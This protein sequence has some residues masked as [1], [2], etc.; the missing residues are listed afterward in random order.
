MKK[1]MMGLLV[2]LM[3]VHAYADKEYVCIDLKTGKD[4]GKFRG[5][6]GHIIYSNLRTSA[7]G[8]VLKINEDG[9]LYNADL[10]VQHGRPF[11]VGAV[12]YENFKLLVNMSGHKMICE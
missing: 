5:E 12:V 8:W 2:S 9:Q 6:N 11:Y 7:E 1:L 10:M 3:A 4:A